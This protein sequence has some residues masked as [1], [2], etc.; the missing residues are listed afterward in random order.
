[1]WYTPKRLHIFIFVISL[2][3]GSILWNVLSFI[4][5][6]L[7]LGDN[8]HWKSSRLYCNWAPFTELFPLILKSTVHSIYF[9]SPKST[10]YIKNHMLISVYYDISNKTSI[11]KICRLFTHESHFAGS[12]T[13]VLLNSFDKLP[14][15]H[16]IGTRQIKMYQDNLVTPLTLL[17][18]CKWLEIKLH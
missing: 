12:L 18:W 4:Q 2:F 15:W 1:M 7:L 5:I 3:Y 8:P 9:L 11:I 17:N 13:G 14:A 16:K 10:C 6:C